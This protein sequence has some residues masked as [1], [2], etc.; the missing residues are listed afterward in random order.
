M[1]D[2]CQIWSPNLFTPALPGQS[3]NSHT[4]DSTCHNSSSADIKQGTVAGSKL[5][6]GGSGLLLPTE[7]GKTAR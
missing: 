3:G 2:V 7:E 1:A 4:T 5:K 6:V